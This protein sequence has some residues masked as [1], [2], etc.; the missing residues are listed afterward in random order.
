MYASAERALSVIDRLVTGEGFLTASAAPGADEPVGRYA[1]LFGRDALIAALQIL[2]ARPDIATATVAALG[3]RQGRRLVPETA[4][5]PGKIPH[6]DWEVA[7]QWHRDRSWRVEP[8]GSLRY[9][10]SV[11]STSLYLILA[12]RLKI[13]DS[14]VTAALHWLRSSLAANGLITYVGHREGGLYHQGWRDGLWDKEGSG[15]RWPSGAQVEGPVA[16]ASA[17][18]FAYH[19]LRCHGFEAEA[20][21]LADA[22]DESFFRHGQPWPAL[23]VDGHGRAV[24]T[25]ASEIG[26]M[27]WSDLLKPARVEPAVSALRTLMTRWGPRTISPEHASFSPD[28]YHLGAVWPF[29][30]WFA[31][32][33]L[34]RHGATELADRVRRGVLDAVEHLHCMPECYAA[35]LDGGPP[36]VPGRATRL[37]AWTAGAVW[38][39]ASGW[40]GRPAL[41]SG[42]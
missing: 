24:P 20:E 34:R 39:L 17:Q 16:V 21:Q 1:T 32:G 37:Q 30:C 13:R 12:A 10:G 3:S 19:A 28:A 29:E 41:A 2:P 9:F 40:D 6:E 7:P 35:P 11:D 22:V 23:A 31:W 15:V 38:A 36:F 14:T 27:L 26:I 33:A 25:K 42:C 8:D 5:E 18:A 4:E